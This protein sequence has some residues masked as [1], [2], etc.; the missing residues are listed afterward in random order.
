M[1]LNVHANYPHT[2]TYVLKLHRDC[3]PR[4]GR[5]AGRLE[6]IAS[7]HTLHF[8]S[9]EQLLACIASLDVAGQEHSS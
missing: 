8:D 9:L 2:R 7:G 1:I 6:H 4:D 5:I 3:A